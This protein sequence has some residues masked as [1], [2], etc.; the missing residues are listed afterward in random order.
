M[1]GCML[2]LLCIVPK[3]GYLLRL[4]RNIIMLPT[5]ICRSA[6]STDAASKSSGGRRETR[7]VFRRR[8]M[9]LLKIKRNWKATGRRAI[10]NTYILHGYEYLYIPNF[11]LTTG[12]DIVLGYFVRLQCSI[13][14]CSTRPVIYKIQGTEYTLR[15][16]Q[17]T[18]LDLITYAPP[19]YVLHP[20]HPHWRPSRR[21]PQLSSPFNL[22]RT[23]PRPCCTIKITINSEAS[24][25]RKGGDITVDDGASI[26]PSI[27]KPME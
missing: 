17:N 22:L 2:R 24:V 25:V 11:M 10:W 1:F 3:Y 27:L 23:R 20:P 14:R 5:S 18:R 26:H 13:Y 8:R 4:S 19:P 15:S 21:N 6:W 9:I 12:K 16:K 7:L